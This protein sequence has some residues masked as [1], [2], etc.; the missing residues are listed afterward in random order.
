M[1]AAISIILVGIGSLLAGWV[2]PMLSHSLP[3]WVQIGLLVLGL[4]LIVGG[5]ILA[6]GEKRSERGGIS[7]KMRDGNRI[8]QIGNDIERA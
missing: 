3:H 6:I 2:I 1:R 8:G 5:A 7:V 4:L